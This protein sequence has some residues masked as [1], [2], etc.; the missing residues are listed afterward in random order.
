MI[1]TGLKVKKC[2]Y[3]CP[4]QSGQLGTSVKLFLFFRSCFEGNCPVKNVG[5][6]L[7]HI[8]VIPQG[9]WDQDS[10]KVAIFLVS[11]GHTVKKSVHVECDRQQV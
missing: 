11:V 1:N 7:G 6:T 10:E 4:M 5:Y 9:S 3:L 2:T 8:R